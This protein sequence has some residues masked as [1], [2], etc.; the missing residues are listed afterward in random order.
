[1]KRPIKPV[2]INAG[3]WLAFGLALLSSIQHLQYT[4]STLEWPGKMGQFWGWVAAI[5]VDSGLAALAYSIQQ[6]K[7][8]KR[9]T[10]VLWGG[11]AGFAVISAVANVYHALSV[12]SGGAFASGSF[13]SVDWLLVLL[14]VLLS[15][16]L[17]AMVIYLGEIVSSDD[18]AAAA[19]AEREERKAEREAEAPRIEIVPPPALPEPERVTCET[20]GRVFASQNGLNAHQRKHQEAEA[21]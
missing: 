20:C 18:A 14:A 3:L 1:M 9:P 2:I 12:K 8:A 6:R 15:A 17:P 10:G 5:A 11:V 13:A 7:R 16:V 19:R 21:K 4:F